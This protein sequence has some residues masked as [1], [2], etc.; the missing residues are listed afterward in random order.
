MDFKLFLGVVK[1]YKRIVISGSVLA[2]LLSML[3]YGMPGLK[4]GKP[5]IIPRGS[6]VWQANAELLISEEGFPYGRAVTQVIPGKG[7]DIPAQT[8]GD[9]GY[10]ASL[11]SVYAAMANGT[12]LQHQVATEAHVRVC[13]AGVSA[14]GSSASS[15]SA[16]TCGTVTAAEVAD[17]NTSAPLPL[18]TLTASAPTA[19]EATKIATTTLSVLQGNI[20]RQ[21]ADAGTPVDQRVE[22]QTL[23]SGAVA[24][25]TQG[26]SKSIPMLVLFAIVSASIALAFILNSHSDDPVR[27]TRRRL[28][29]GQ[30]LDGG[31]SAGGGN[32]R[33][34]EPEHGLLQ[35]R[36][37]RTQLIGLR[38]GAS[39][40]RPSNEE[41]AATHRT[42]AEESSATD[43][44]RAW[45][46]R[47]PPFSPRTSGFEP[48]SRD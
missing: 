10:L 27:P 32:G 14:A 23:Q 36:G 7:L 45:S 3:S 15:S 40:T 31:P 20:T 17:P 39:G 26:H 29:E 34:A 6:E 37:A 21:E 47:T 22:L 38:R 18:I 30:G 24:A 43:R 12:S 25:L 42:V 41:N 4:G 11:S 33:V 8:Y 2:V 35:T 13:P 16:G 48:E 19:G 9:E 46:D 28:D 44:R 1:R 5:T